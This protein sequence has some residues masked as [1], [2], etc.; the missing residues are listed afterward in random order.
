MHVPSYYLTQ[1]LFEQRVRDCERKSESYRILQQAG[2]D[3]RGWL[4]T[5]AC[6]LLSR[7]GCLLV[8]LGRRLERTANS[9]V[10]SPARL[11]GASGA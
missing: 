8:A 5:G 11:P 7:L 6:A 10:S 4:A 2:V 1:R 9:S 3:H